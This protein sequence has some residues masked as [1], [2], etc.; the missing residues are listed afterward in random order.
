[1]KSISFII[2]LLFSLSFNIFS[3]NVPI[4]E[5]YRVVPLDFEKAKIQW[6]LK[7]ESLAKMSENEIKHEDLTKEER[8]AL[9]TYSEVYASIWDIV[10]AGCSWYCGGGVKEISA[11][12]Y[13]KSQ[14][15]N[16]YDPS[17][18]HDL[19]Y[20]TAWVE[21]VD[22]YGIG[23]KLLYTFQATNP[24]ITDIIIVNGYVK[25]KSAY[26]NNSR[27][28]KLKVYKDEI[29]VATLNLKD[30]IA[31]QWFAFEAIG[32][33]DR[34]DYEALEKQPDWSL[35]F[36][37]VEVY[38]GDK[39]DDTVLS[40]IYFNGIDVHCFVA[41]TQIMTADFTTKNIE[42]LKVGEQI[43]YK[44]F[45]SGQLKTTTIDQLQ[46][47][48]HHNLVTYHFE[49]DSSITGTKDH[50]FQLEN[51]GWSSLSPEKSKH[52]QGFKVINLIEI[53][54]SFMTND[55]VKVL[56][57]IEYLEGHHNT[58]TISKVSDGNNFIANGFIVGVEMLNYNN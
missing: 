24:R 52:Y 1:M 22:G 5:P 10:G 2:S 42:D 30:T 14:G 18:A 3:Q 33:T 49:D 41:G 46:Q 38:E 11:S 16:S 15:K 27:V 31:E 13:L 34:S 12:S 51:K 40:E 35:T 53:G 28:K 37:I 21:G 56:K 7:E 44:D 9:Q 25:S 55:G 45:D 47:A 19:D 20:E 26:Q 54:D 6:D 58:Y 57:K 43:I 32:V 48:R 4:V 8:I 36:E 39:Y 23:E 17:N 50:P 29:P